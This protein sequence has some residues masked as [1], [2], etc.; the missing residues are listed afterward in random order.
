MAYHNNK[1]KVGLEAFLQHH[2]SPYRPCKLTLQILS[3]A[4]LLSKAK[5]PGRPSKCPPPRV[6]QEVVP[7]QLPSLA[8]GTAPKPVYMLAAIK[9]SPTL[10]LSFR[11][12]HH[13]PHLRD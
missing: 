9:G 11:M 3:K 1:K 4:A 12:P 13:G 6:S 8:G 2:P 5:V 7:E 10:G